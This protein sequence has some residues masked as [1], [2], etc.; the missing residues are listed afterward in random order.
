[1]LTNDV[2]MTAVKFNKVDVLR[3]VLDPFDWGEIPSITQDHLDRA[4]VIC[5]QNNYVEL[6]QLMLPSVDLACNRFN[7]LCWALLKDHHDILNLIVTRIDTF[8]IP[9]EVVE[10]MKNVGV[11][12]RWEQFQLH[13]ALTQATNKAGVSSSNRKI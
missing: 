8:P 10:K 6:A 11:W 9:P 2:F 3:P 4:F 1:M 7:G 13:N 12:E 5:C